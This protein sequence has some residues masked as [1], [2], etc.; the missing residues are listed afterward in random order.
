MHHAGVRRFVAV[1]AL[2]VTPRAEVGRAERWVVF[3][4]LSRFLGEMYADMARM[5]QVLRDSD[6]DWTIMRPPQLTNKAATGKYRTGINLNRPGNVA[7]SI[8]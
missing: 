8:R 6:L 4:L 1:S 3:P 5:E 2:P 7:G